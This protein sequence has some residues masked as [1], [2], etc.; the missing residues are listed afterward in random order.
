MDVA[1]ALRDVQRA[2][3]ETRQALARR[4]NMGVS[5]VAAM[6]QVIFAA[7]PL[8]PVELG[9]RLGMRSA[10]ATALVDRL[11]RAGHLRRVPHPSDR[12]RQ[13]LAPT[14][15]AISEVATALRPL[16]DAISAAA[17]ELTPDQA[18]VVTQFLRTASQIMH[19]FAAASPDEGRA[20]AR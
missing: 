9:N 6:D 13:T 16:I 4:L 5:D 2:A 19:D 1:V 8:G 7:E 17:A 11:E 15:H 12:R 14:E 20:P 3:A 10:S 18:T